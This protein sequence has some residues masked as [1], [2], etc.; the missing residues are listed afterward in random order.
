MSDDSIPSSEI[1]LNSFGLPWGEIPWDERCRREKSLEISARDLAC[2]QITVNLDDLLDVRKLAAARKRKQARIEAALNSL[3]DDRRHAPPVRLPSA[4]LDSGAYFP[5]PAFNRFDEPLPICGVT[6]FPD[7]IEIHQPAR[8]SEDHDHSGGGTRGQITEFSAA[9]RLRLL[10][11]MCQLRPGKQDIYFFTLTYSDDYTNDG[12]VWKRDLDRFLDRLS[13]HFPASWCLWRME[14]QTRKSGDRLGEIAP[15][16]HILVGG[17]DLSIIE[18][19]PDFA[20]TERDCRKN[21]NTLRLQAWVKRNWFACNH[22][23]DPAAA[24]RGADV[25]FLETRKKAFIYVS[26]YAAKLETLPGCAANIGRIWGKRGALPLVTGIN[27]PLTLGEVVQLKRLVRAWMKSRGKSGRK[28]AKK[29]AR[30]SEW[31]LMT[32]F[33]LGSDPSWGGSA[34]SP[35]IYKFLEAATDLDLASRRSQV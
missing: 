16:F 9:S 15:H 1:Q 31:S 25:E 4:T 20:L 29:L 5:K 34:S 32:I 6:L 8:P 3:P 2:R 7:M 21:E 13:Y 10:R 19:Q 26:K 28:F 27:I 33:G 35:P 24:R 12:Q 17:L 23:S 30:R 11:L 22:V 14:F 18:D